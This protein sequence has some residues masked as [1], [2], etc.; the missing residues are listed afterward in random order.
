MKK[1]CLVPQNGPESLGP[2]KTTKNNKFPKTYFEPIGIGGWL[3]ISS[4]I[5][6]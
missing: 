1:H 6:E 4:S 2:E 3:P 5:I